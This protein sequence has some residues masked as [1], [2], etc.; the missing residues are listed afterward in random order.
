MHKEMR[1][2]ILLLFLL[3]NSPLFLFAQDVFDYR[4]TGRVLYKVSFQTDT[5]NAKISEEVA[6]LL[7]NDS[8]SLFR[9]VNQG[10]RDSALQ[11]SWKVGKSS[12][13]V[14]FALATAT[15]LKFRIL[16]SGDAIHTFDGIFAGDA[17]IQYRYT[18]PVDIL[19]WEL[20]D[21]TKTI[22]G[23]QCQRAEVELGGRRWV[24]WFA[25]EI[26]LG[27]GPYKFSQLPGLVISIADTTGTW[28]MDFIGI[29]DNYHKDIVMD[30]YIPEPRP[31]VSK[32]KFFKMKNEARDNA[33]MIIVAKGNSNFTNLP[34]KYKKI[35]KDTIEKGMKADNNWIELHP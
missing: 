4:F 29:S 21:D 18:E 33:F 34:E 1:Y 9:S 20:Y 15:G 6:E 19:D 27:L 16:T 22:A 25:P 7:Y 10:K 13:P 26:P 8:A 31:K 5:L 28:N 30:R 12:Y 23:L 2:T 24:A 14:S 11:E 3:F 32:Q 17:L 35:A